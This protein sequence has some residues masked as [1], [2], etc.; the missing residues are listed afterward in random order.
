M[1]VCNVHSLLFAKILTLCGTLGCVAECGM[2]VRRTEEK[3]PALK[4]A[5]GNNNTQ[6]ISHSLASHLLQFRQMH[7]FFPPAAVTQQNTNQL[8][9]W[10]AGTMI[11]MVGRHNPDEKRSEIKSEDSLAKEIQGTGC[12]LS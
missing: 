8:N 3:L 7:T 10:G 2:F 4:C 12:R 11:L 5:S 6:K 9:V 1:Q